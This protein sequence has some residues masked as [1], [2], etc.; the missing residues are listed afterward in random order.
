VV[1]FI[2]TAAAAFRGISFA[3]L[4]LC[5]RHCCLLLIGLLPRSF[6]FGKII[7][8]IKTELLIA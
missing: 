3:C 2:A 8:V 4:L 5:T 6:A 1:G 7:A